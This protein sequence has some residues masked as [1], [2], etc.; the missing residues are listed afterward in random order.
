MGMYNFPTLNVAQVQTIQ[1]KICIKYQNINDNMYG[2]NSGI[3]NQT[4]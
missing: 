1:N 3:N 2:T 4:R